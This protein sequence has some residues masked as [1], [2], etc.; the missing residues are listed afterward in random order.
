[1]ELKQIK[2]NNMKK[3]I[4]ISALML[5]TA[6]L[7]FTGCSTEDDIANGSLQ[8]E[9]TLT[10]GMGALTDGNAGNKNVPRIITCRKLS[11]E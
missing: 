1:M 3:N 7:S 8:K 2:T 5:L 11:V 10:G 6:G 9:Y 4:F